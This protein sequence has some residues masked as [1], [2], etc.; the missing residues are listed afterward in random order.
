MK[1]KNTHITHLRIKDERKEKENYFIHKQTLVQ[2][3]YLL[4]FA[5]L[6]LR[7]TMTVKTILC[8]RLK[9]PRFV[10]LVSSKWKHCRNESLLYYDIKSRI[11]SSTKPVI[12]YPQRRP[13]STTNKRYESISPSS[14]SSSSVSNDE[15]SK[16]SS[17][18][19]TWWNPDQNPLISMNPTRMEFIISTLE[20]NQNIIIND[21]NDNK[22]SS[23]LLLYEPL[24]GLKALDVGCGG[25]LLSESLARLGANVTAIDPSEEVAN[26]AYEH[27]KL[28]SRLENKIEYKGGTSVEDLAF[29]YN[30][31]KNKTNNS[32]VELYDVICI[33]EVIEHATNPTSLLQ[34]A[35]SLL[36][37]P[38]IDNP[39]GGMLFISTINRTIKS[40]GI[41]ILGGEY[42]TGKLPIGTHSWNSFLSPQEVKGL[43]GKFGLEEVNMT[44]MVLK[45]PFYD[46]RWEMN[47]LDTDVNWI[48]AYSHHNA[49]TS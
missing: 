44:G 24:K 49:D 19:S 48:G 25:G 18:A 38:S 12:L 1:S 6:A 23:S 16:F 9:D 40:Y 5:I 26:A 39:K 27:S 10:S 28:D 35:I 22:S 20:Q 13:Y 47:K 3:F 43:V 31:E 7:Y 41:A 15:V 2:S 4:R 42:I 34:N 17:M 21:R 11:S 29:E 8:S 32:D 45:P 46:L 33:L 37:P 36:K 30:K 14:S